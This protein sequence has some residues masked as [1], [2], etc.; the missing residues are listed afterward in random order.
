[1]DFK[2][3]LPV[4]T[5]KDGASFVAGSDYAV[6][7]GGYES[8]GATFE[9]VGI[10]ASREMFV[11]EASMRSAVKAQ[12]AAFSSGDNGFHVLAVRQDVLA[13]STDADGDYSSIKVNALG[14]VYVR[15]NMALEIEIEE[16]APHVSGQKGILPLAV[17]NDLSATMTDADGDNS[18]LTTD[19]TG[20]MRVTVVDPNVSSTEIADYITSA[21]LAV[22]ATA[23]HDFTVSASKVFKA[24]DIWASASG[25]I[26]IELIVD[27]A[28]SAVTKAVGFN[29]TANPN[30]DIPLKGRVEAA[31]GTVVRVAVTN[32]D[33]DPQ[34]VYSTLFGNEI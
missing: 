2:S 18:P 23:N 8:V 5:H 30:I 33:E 14:E 28:G 27:P 11:V 17:R 1:M 6:M 12:D 4:K 29:S 19:K 15:G 13:T 24:E 25:R 26:K 16:D 7:I 9:A 10:N 20:A 22:G 34:D 31:A 32:L 21:S 3:H